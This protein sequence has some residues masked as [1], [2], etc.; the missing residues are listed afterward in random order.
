MAATVQA[1]AI[2]EQQTT[3]NSKVLDTTTVAHQ[4]HDAEKADEQEPPPAQSTKPSLERWNHPRINMFRFL[5]TNYSFI[6]MGMNDACVG[7]LLPYIEA[8][9]NISHTLMST[10]FLASFVGYFLAA[11]SNNL[12]HH[13]LGQRGVA[14]SAPIARLIGYIPMCLHPPFAALP[15]IML[16][17]GFGNGIEDSAWNAWIGNM[18]NANELL[19]FLHGCYGLGAT[20]GPLIAT[21]MVT[22]AGLPWYQYYYL[23]IGLTGLELVLTTTSFW[24]ATGAV[25]RAAHVGANGGARITTRTVMKSPIVWL[26]AFFFLGYV[27]AEVSLGGWIVTFMLV[28]R[29]AEAF[30][31]GLTVTFFW[32]GLTV[33]RVTLGFVTGRIGEKLA[34]TVYLMLSIALQ[35][36][37]WLIPSFIASAVF[38]AFEGFFLGPLF[39]AAVVAATKLLPIEYHV[40]AIGFAAAFGGGGAAVFPF[41]VGAIASTRGVQVLQPIILAIFVFILVLWLALPGGLRRGGLEHARDTDEKIGHQLERVYKWLTQRSGKRERS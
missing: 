36:L 7:A 40:S 2:E 23:M 10:L 6:I 32:L 19:G 25:Y 11:L 38:V 30:Q 24:G 13:H 4:S 1:N 3:Q 31:A 28:V 12:I 27:G 15:P 9:Y 35:L 8:Y 26:V 17:P 22:K 14:I 41:A 5:V 39:P 21:A 33:G 37:Y 29:G 34:I 18:E 20:I 16:F